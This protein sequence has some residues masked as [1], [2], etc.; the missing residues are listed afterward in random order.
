MQ[1][2]RAVMF[3]DNSNIFQNLKLVRPGYRI[4]YKKLH[5]KIEEGGEI[6]ETYFFA[7][8]R[9]GAPRETQT[10]FFEVLRRELNYNIVLAGLKVK[11]VTCRFCGQTH[12][13]YIEKGV[14]V[15]LAT[16]LLSLLYSNAFDTAIVVS[17]DGDYVEVVR[18]VRRLGRK[19]QIVSFR[20]SLSK[21]L[22]NLSSSDPIYL[23]DIANE[24]ELEREY[25]PSYG[26][27]D[28]NPT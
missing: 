22:A 17:G 18:E 14:D 28:N 15:G 12:E 24:I 26:E 7:A 21:E 3:I 25:Y 2:G 4:D 16:R 13:A 8:E 20:E 19:V 9:E 1:R 23:D 6:W 10:A 5:K 11:T 27:M